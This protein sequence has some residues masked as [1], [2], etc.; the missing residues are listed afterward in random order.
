MEADASQPQSR[1]LG[2]SRNHLQHI[3]QFPPGV[4]WSTWLVWP[5]NDLTWQICPS[6]A[7]RVGDR[8]PPECPIS[9]ACN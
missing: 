9:A 3:A 2:Y 7:A 4:L 5:P 8:L 1:F 6:S